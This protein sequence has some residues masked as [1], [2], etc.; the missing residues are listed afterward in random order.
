MAEDL[1]VSLHIGERF[2]L[3]EIKILGLVDKHCKKS[4]FNMKLNLEKIYCQNRH[5]EP[6]L[7]SLIN[8]T[9]MILRPHD[10]FK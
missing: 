8:L 3:M 5:V 10:P 1:C 6:E 4:I 2:I 9:N 7:N